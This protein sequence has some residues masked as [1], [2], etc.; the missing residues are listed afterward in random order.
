[1][2]IRKEFY[3]KGKLWSVEYRWGLRAKEKC[4]GLCD[5][6]NRIIY[7]E[8]S[9]SKEEK[10]STFIHE[11]THAALYEAHINPSSGLSTESEE[12]VCDAMEDLLTSLFTFRWK[13]S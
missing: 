12:I 7:L 3:I 1:M 11:I 2:K 5:F 13:R 4:S 9:D 8:R 6:E 10:W